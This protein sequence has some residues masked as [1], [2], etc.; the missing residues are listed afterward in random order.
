LLQAEPVQKQAKL[1][2]GEPQ[3]ED[4]EAHGDPVAPARK[5]SI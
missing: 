3:E 2:D 4:G 5:G 1:G